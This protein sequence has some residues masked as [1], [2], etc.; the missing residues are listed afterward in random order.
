MAR[1]YRSPRCIDLVAVGGKA[2]VTGVRWKR[3]F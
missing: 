3:R 1:F 2:D